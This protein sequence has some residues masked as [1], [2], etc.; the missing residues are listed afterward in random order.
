M[1]SLN[2]SRMI[3]RIP[4]VVM[5]ARKTGAV[6]RHQQ[7]DD[8]HAFLEALCPLLDRRKRKPERLVFG[9]VPGGTDAQLEASI[10]DVVY[11]DR[12]GRQDRRMA[13]GDPGHQHP[14]SNPR[15]EGGEPCQKRPPFQ[16]WAIWIA[17]K[18]GE[19]VEDPG[20]VE[21]SR[22]RE[23]HPFGQLRPQELVL[24]DV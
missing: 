14:E 13:V 9:L 20:T 4:E 8:L 15:S 2:G 22:L 6:L 12:L 1:R 3:T 23:S 5:P 21:S 11:R 10:G 24:R 19:V 7:P 16:A 18:R 17:V